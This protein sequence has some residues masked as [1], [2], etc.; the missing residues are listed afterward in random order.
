MMLSRRCET[1]EGEGISADLLHARFMV[2]DRLKKEVELQARFGRD[3][4]RDRGRVLVA[5]QVV[6][7]SLDLDFDLMVSDL[8]P[9]G[10]LIQRAGRLWRHMDLRPVRERPVPGPVLHILS[11]DP[12]NVEDGRWLHRVLPAGA[13]VYPLSDQWCTARA[14]F[15]LG[16]I[17]APDGLRQLIEAVHGS[18]SGRGTGNLEP[19]R[20]G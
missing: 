19:C 13:W 1:L 18:G 14:V 11:P 20:A 7:A 4:T 2:A 5:T 8:A 6:E 9:I 10:S 17:R 16:A 3:G 15:A 12:E